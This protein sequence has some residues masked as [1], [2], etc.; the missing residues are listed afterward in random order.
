MAEHGWWLPSVRPSKQRGWL[1]IMKGSVNTEHT[2]NNEEGGQPTMEQRVCVS[3]Q[4][5][6]EYKE[7]RETRLATN[8][9][10][11]SKSVY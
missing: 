7:K 4:R 3:K 9:D 10:C 11:M 2:M 5:V 8:H 1:E 6:A